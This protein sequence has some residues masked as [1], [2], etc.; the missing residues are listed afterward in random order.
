MAA[1]MRPRA[2]TFGHIDSSAMG[3]FALNNALASNSVVPGKL[4][5]HPSMSGLPNGYDYR[6]MST[7]L[8]SHGNVGG[9][10]KLNT[11]LGIGLGGGLPTAPLPG[12]A[13]SFD[14]DNLFGGSTV[15]PAQLHF[16]DALGSPTSPFQTFPPFQ[17]MADMTREDDFDFLNGMDGSMV[18]NSNNEHAIDESSPS[19]FSTASQSGLSE[20]MVDG[21]N[22]AVP[23]TTAIWSDAL[24]A[25]TIVDPNTFSVEGISASFG[26]LHTFSPKEMQD[27]HQSPENFLFSTPPPRNPM[28][29]GQ[30]MRT[31]PNQLY[32]NSI[33]LG[34]DS[35]SMSSNSVNG[36]VRHSSVTSVST[37]SIN[38]GIRNAL[39]TSLSQPSGFGHQYRKFPQPAVSS[40]LSPGFTGK[41]SQHVATLPSTADLQ[42]YVSAY[43]HYFHPHMPF[44]HIP[45]LSFDS[46]DFTSGLR[47]SAGYGPDNIVGGGGC[48]ILAMAAIGAL[49]EFE[50]TAAK[51]LFEAAKRM[52]NIY[53][54]ERRRAGVMAAS[55]ISHAAG[56]SNQKTPL[57]LVQAMLL[58]LIF[59]H[60][61]GDKVAADIASTHCAALVSLAKSADLENPEPEV[62]QDELRQS[63]ARHGSTGADTDM[64]D[65][66]TS[67]GSW[68]HAGANEAQELHAEW[69]KWKIQEERKRT[70]F[71]VF[72]LSSLL[73]TAYNH[74]PR[75]MNS[76]LHLTLPCDEDL[77]AAESAQSWAT[78]GGAAR[79][80][81]KAISFAD[82]LTFLLT[83][84]QR[85]Q[86]EYRATTTF[87]RPGGS[88]I[89]R[90]QLPESELKPSTFGCY[91]LINALHV[92]IW[93][94][95][96][97][98]SGRQWKAQETEQ[99]H[100][101]IEP[102]LKAWQAAWAASPHHT[103]ERPS[104]HG[105]LPAD[106]IPLLDL[107]YV[108]LFVNLGRSKDA[109]WQRDFDLMAEEL[110]K[111]VEII[112]HAEE[113][114]PGSSEPLE[115]KPT[116][117][118]TGP[119][120]D[121]VSKD[122]E[123]SARNNLAPPLPSMQQAGPMTKRERHLRKAA[124]YAA[125]SLKMAD[126]LGH[127]FAEFTSRELPIQSAMCRF[128]CVQ[129]LAE[130]VAT[131]QERV[132]RYLGILGRDEIDYMQVPAVI[133]LEEEDA[134][135]LRTIEEILNH[136]NYNIALD[137]SG[138]N[139]MSGN[140]TLSSAGLP[141]S[142]Q[143][144]FGSKL[145]LVTGYMLG[146]SAVWPS[147]CSVDQND[148]ANE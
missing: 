134:K 93:E 72:V 26:D 47:M 94:T 107:A 74:H 44:L 108:R 143:F 46:P 33:M 5:R 110:G 60:N 9:L 36:S 3:L 84:S 85:Q 86:A 35:T 87:H 71:A 67:P 92:Y 95:R 34:S 122:A 65:D 101:Q 38:D 120:N 59:G 139:N 53:L 148:S 69:Y 121:T 96:Q 114:R 82:A 98:H 19:A 22:T 50:H 39:I 115:S 75:V 124:N 145:L 123:T 144:G 48:L 51:N 78:L 141:N 146:K 55:N 32:Q 45:T 31:L 132:G 2:N 111:G 76:E 105:P 18:M 42:R 70:L 20:V 23:A 113:S 138:M 81:A 12:M 66:A 79:A 116:I 24:A 112:Q 14:M 63:G 37:D 10:P 104:P 4:S 103:M 128:D 83:A 90:E 1:N 41:V 131:V 21:S 11:H 68:N 130:W 80:D 57:W 64:G 6:G 126:N 127:T 137:M 25:P 142:S 52:I 129:V 17:N 135:L 77:W 49:Y 89:A 147:K 28:S 133:L 54:E 58:N 30:G 97:R 16:N 119:P 15:N 56:S 109:F 8:G 118:N 29:P 27:F 117:S 40:P 102:A 73:V 43:I 61:C 106:S 7:A 99:M 91:I 125:D 100:A 88:T 13:N 140:G 136:A 62:S